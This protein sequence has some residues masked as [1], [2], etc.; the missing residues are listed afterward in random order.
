VTGAKDLWDAAGAALAVLFE[1]A[2]TPTARVGLGARHILATGRHRRVATTRFRSLARCGEY[3]GRAV[4]TLDG[5]VIG[6]VWR[7]VRKGE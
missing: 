4:A 1:I 5:K 3:A 7:T 6:Q 2:A